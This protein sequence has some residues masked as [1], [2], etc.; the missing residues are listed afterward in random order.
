M[1]QILARKDAK[2]PALPVVQQD[3]VTYICDGERFQVLEQSV[4]A[5]GQTLLVD[6]LDDPQRYDRQAPVYIESDKV[7]FR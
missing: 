4:R 5:R 6:V 1:E 3:V 7:K 2:Q